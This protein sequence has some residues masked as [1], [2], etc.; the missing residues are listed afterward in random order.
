MPTINPQQ[1]AL[2][3]QAALV[4][5]ALALADARVEMLRQERTRTMAAMNEAGMS[6]AE[7]ARAFH[8]TPQAAMY[9]T[10]H[11]QRTPRAKKTPVEQD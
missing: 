1:E 3:Q 11:A 4:E 8:V 5:H 7:I 6:W 10:G 9:A 2:A